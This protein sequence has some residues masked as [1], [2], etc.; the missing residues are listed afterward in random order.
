M[1]VA[2]IYNN[3]IYIGYV[4][5]VPRGP[6]VTHK[7]VNGLLKFNSLWKCGNVI[8]WLKEVGAIQKCAV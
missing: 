4:N 3:D 6:H 1:L 2:A 7:N 8:N 5:L